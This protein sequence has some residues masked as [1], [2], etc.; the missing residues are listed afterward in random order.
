VANASELRNAVGLLRIGEKVELGLVHEGKPRR[1]TA[2]IGQRGSAEG[3][4]AAD[5]H[6]ALEGAALATADGGVLVQS[7]ADGSPAALNGLRPND[8]I[9]AIGRARVSNVDQLRAAARNQSAFAMTI[10]RG[11]STLVFPIR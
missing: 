7:V 5:I 10:R 2:M 1:V 4:A 8:V 6:E 9:L 3:D 11:N